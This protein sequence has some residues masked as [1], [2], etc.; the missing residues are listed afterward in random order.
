MVSE[1]APNNIF[2]SI[3]CLLLYLALLTHSFHSLLDS[4][5]EA[6]CGA[7]AE[8]I[9][10]L[11]RTP[12]FGLDGAKLKRLAN[13]NNSRVLNQLVDLAVQ[14][15][16]LDPSQRPTADK[17]V[18][19]LQRILLE[20]QATQLR[21]SSHHHATTTNSAAAK[22]STRRVTRVNSFDAKQH[23]P[24]PQGSNRRRL[25]RSLSNSRSRGASDSDR[26][27]P[28]QSLSSSANRGYVDQLPL[29]PVQSAN[30]MEG[31]TSV[32]MS[33]VEDDQDDGDEF[34]S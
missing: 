7:E 33:D 28:P 20:Y 19:Q 2:P 29:E 30:S 14:C 6:V 13:P 9:V 1:K 21:N 26:V 24:S 12:D 4:I 16:S 15:C 34:Y 10:D 27:L 25:S 22:L 31:D 11:T 23:L 32:A 17:M 8:D 3:I 5:S 18:N